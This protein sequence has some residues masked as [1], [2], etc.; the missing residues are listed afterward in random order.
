MAHEGHTAPADRECVISF[1]LN[2]SLAQRAL[3]VDVVS[4]LVGH[5]ETADATFR[6]E[7]VTAFGEAFNNVVLHGYRGRSNGVLEVEVEIA[8]DQMT[9]RMMDTGCAVDFGSVAVPELDTMPEGGMGVFMIHSL[10]DHV[11]YRRGAPNVLTL[12][13][14][15]TNT[16][17][18]ADGDE[19]GPHR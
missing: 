18:R 3:A 14:R 16:A 1:R 13:K 6:H 17:T 12:S 9:L 5:V 15:T 2:A 7:L 4:T 11:E 10:V 8:P 19:L